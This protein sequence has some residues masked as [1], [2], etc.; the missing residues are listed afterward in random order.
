[1]SDTR[2]TWTCQC[3][4]LRTDLVKDCMTVSGKSSSGKSH[5]QIEEDRFRGG[6]WLMAVMTTTKPSCI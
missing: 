4:V 2:E 6:G 3:S 5:S 1:M